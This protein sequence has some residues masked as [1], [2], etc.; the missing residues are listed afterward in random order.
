MSNT[1]NKK[2]SNSILGNKN[3]LG[4]NSES[5][6]IKSEKLKDSF[7]HKHV[8]SNDRYENE[9][10]TNL[11]EKSISK[12]FNSTKTDIQESNIFKNSPSKLNTKYNNSIISNNN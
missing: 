10:K 8:N 6:M 4:N 1:L 5:L 3:E 7:N 12:T 11:S 9:N 2:R